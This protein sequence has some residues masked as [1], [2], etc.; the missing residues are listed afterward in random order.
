MNQIKL[1]N[2]PITKLY[3]ILDSYGRYFGIN[4]LEYVNNLIL[5]DLFILESLIELM[6]IK[7]EIL[8]NRIDL[9]RFI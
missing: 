7:L 4:F 6:S 9:I 2:Y 3:I 1:F 8:I 5:D